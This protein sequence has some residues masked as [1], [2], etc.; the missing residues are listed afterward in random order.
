MTLPEAFLTRGLEIEISGRPY[1]I[2]G[3][4][5]WSGLHVIP[6]FRRQP[7]D[8]R[9]PDLDTIRADDPRISVCYYHWNNRAKAVRFLESERYW[10]AYPLL[11][12]AGPLKSDQSR[13]A[14]TEAMRRACE[15]EPPVIGVLGPWTTD[16]EP[17]EPWEK[18]AAAAGTW[19]GADWRRDVLVARWA[20][21]FERP[22]RALGRDSYRRRQGPAWRA[23]WV[24]G[25]APDVAPVAPG[26]VAER[27]PPPSVSH[28]GDAATST[29]GKAAADAV[30]ATAWVLL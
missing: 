4:S 17:R 6:E 15:G 30:L 14:V 11:D 26:R 3:R 7:G 28:R 10:W 19:D 21:P 13:R 22:A 12:G 24:T 9:E 23:D 2:V 25:P 27:R 5:L 18:A 20:R 1:T 8:D 29:E 16:T